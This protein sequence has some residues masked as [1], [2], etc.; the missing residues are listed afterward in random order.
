[1]SN[2]VHV[3]GSRHALRAFPFFALRRQLHFSS[4]SL[5]TT[6]LRRIFPFSASGLTAR[7]LHKL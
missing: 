5:P 7:Q 2:V 3:A 4:S 6:H 1:M